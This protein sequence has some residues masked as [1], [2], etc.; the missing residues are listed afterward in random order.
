[1]TTY[2]TGNPVPSA[3][4]R[5]R[6]DNSQALD[7]VV[8]GDSASYTT[9]TGKQVISLGGMNSRFNNSQE[10]RDSAF[11]LSQEEKQE[12]FQTFLDGTGWSS[13]GAY[14]AG[15]A[16]TSHTQTVD[17]LGQP[18]SLKPS[19]PASL[20]AP[21]IT[22][23]VWAT[24]GVNFKLVG[25]N[26]LRQDMAS[27][28]DPANGTGMIGYIV[29]SQGSVGRTLHNKLAAEHVSIVDFGAIPGGE[30]GVNSSRNALA[31]MRAILHV[32]NKGGGSVRVPAAADGYRTNY[33]PF[34]MD[35]VE[36]YGEGPGSKIIFEDPVFSH[37]RGG[38]VIGSSLE[39]NRNKALAAYNAGTFPAAS[40]L[41][42]TYVN[43]PFGTFLRDNPDKVETRDACVHDLYL[44]AE[45]ASPTGWGGY[46]INF[47][48]SWNC[49]AWNIWGEGWTQLIGMGSDV[50]PET[51]SNHMCTA[52]N[53]H[54]IKPDPYR[55]YYAMGF[56][57]NSTDCFM[58]DQYQ[59]APCTETWESVGK[60]G[61]GI[62]A[63]MCENGGIFGVHVPN[64]GTGPGWSSAGVY[65]ADCKDF[66]V[67]DVYVGNARRAVQ[68]FFFRSAGDPLRPVRIGSN[69]TGKSCEAV[70]SLGSKYVTVAGFQNVGSETDINFFNT[71]VTGCTVSKKPE[72]MT[73]G[74]GLLNYQYL[75]NNKIKGWEPKD[76]YL[77][78]ASILLNDKVDTSGWDAN[79][80]VGAKAGVK[81][82]FLWE[83]PPSVTAVRGFS[84]YTTYAGDAQAAGMSITASIR[85]ML[86]FN[87]NSA[88]T[89]L[90]KQTITAPAVNTTTSDRL[91]TSSTAELVLNDSTAEGL[92][93]SLDFIIEV[94]SPTLNSSVKESRIR[95]YM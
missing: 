82:T 40:T 67:D 53:Y 91:I 50:A 34:V 49:H 63:N 62:A 74:A 47:V 59:H 54:V 6:Y 14:G 28:L 43:L 52:R 65:V 93:N 11:N 83:V 1:M 3:D 7:E 2:N 15:V 55:T 9:R 13:L 24:E 73:F 61:N 51:P 78:P 38:I 69:I 60:E 46:G 57:A 41:D 85:R 79:K 39:A 70:I 30:R 89:A 42:P 81:L 27:L 58:V 87:G 20:D 45:W 66:D 26:S 95:V 84:F 32:Y 86:G 77:R 35:R 48:N 90:I 12:A 29:G 75:D 80:R 33:P 18:Y 37:G 19:I 92:P 17:Y 31:I 8:N 36:L 94:N 72:K 5:D 16:I 44:V 22:T 64:L 76:I 23:G 21:Y 4:A 56:Q 25:D 10:A 88:E 68:T 71:N